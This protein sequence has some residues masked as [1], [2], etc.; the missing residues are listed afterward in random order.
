MTSAALQLATLAVIETGCG[1]EQNTQSSLDQPTLD[2]GFMVTTH[3]LS[4]NINLLPYVMR[5]TAAAGAAAAG[6]LVFDI[7]WQA[8]R[9]GGGEA[10]L[11]V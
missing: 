10:A 5:A 1:E 2:H 7:R 6:G 8:A 11:S 9:A 3:S 4:Q